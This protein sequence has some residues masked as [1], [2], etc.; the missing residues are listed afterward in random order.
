[1]ITSSLFR[2]I[3]SFFSPDSSWDNSIC[4]NHT[5]SMHSVCA[6]ESERSYCHLLLFSP[7]F[8]SLS[9]SPCLS[10][11]FL[12]QCTSFSLS[13]LMVS[14]M[15]YGKLY[16]PQFKNGTSEKT[17]LWHIKTQKYKKHML[18]N[19]SWSKTKIWTYP[20]K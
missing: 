1:M 19:V 13:A 20:G 14:Y 18:Q 12:S 2:I 5:E 7:Y 10:S 3:N 17:W 4:I 6:L 11:L 16:L 15:I 9:L 8:S